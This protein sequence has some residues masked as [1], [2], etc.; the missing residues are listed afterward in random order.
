MLLIFGW[1]VQRTNGRK[2][3]VAIFDFP[4]FVD[5]M[6]LNVHNTCKKKGMFN[7]V[8]STKIEISKIA[9]SRLLNTYQGP[10]RINPQKLT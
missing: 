8:K 5:V 7:Q 9:T 6:R 2:F 1:R 3:K 4:I 10:I